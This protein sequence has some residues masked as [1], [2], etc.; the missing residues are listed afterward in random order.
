MTPWE[1]HAVKY[2]DRNA[3]TRAD[4]FLFDDNHDAPHAMDY[5]IWVLRRGDEVIVVDTGY[6][7]AE[8]TARGRPICLEPAEAL[9]PL[10]IAPHDVTT[11]IVTHLHY[12]H[13]GGLHLFPNATLHMQAA[14]MA[15][16]TGPCMCHDAL[17]MPF[18]ADHICEAVKRLYSG[19]VIF[20]DGD[21]QVADGVTVHCIGG[22][23]RGL[24][25][26]RV[27]TQSGWMVLA[28]DAAHYYENFMKQKPFPIV[29]DLEDMMAGFAT[30][31]RL[32]TAPELIIPGHDP[33]VRRLFPSGVAPH[34]TR[35]DPG[36]QGQVPT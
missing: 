21:A 4:S 5:Y 31:K 15:F 33:L 8:A 25:C 2:A 28:S 22:H 3:R 30:L 1:I 24:Q 34:I 6:D 14:E 11:V 12:D 13:A 35:L 17:R 9:A 18:S 36:P 20:H 27:Q 32:A 19:K 10:G 26:V 7:T 29:V 23:S 16:A